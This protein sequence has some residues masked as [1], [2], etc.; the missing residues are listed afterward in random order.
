MIVGD[1]VLAAPARSSRDDL[2]SRGAALAVLAVC[3]TLVAWV[4]RA[5]AAP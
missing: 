5:G 1:K 2:A 3:A 4:V